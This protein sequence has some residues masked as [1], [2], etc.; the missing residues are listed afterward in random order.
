MEYIKAVIKCEIK[1]M[2]PP[3]KSVRG[4]GEQ[5]GEQPVGVASTLFICIR[6]GRI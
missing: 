2:D 4:V 1:V 6:G 3:L 5:S